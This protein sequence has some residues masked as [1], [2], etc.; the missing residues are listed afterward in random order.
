MA[1]SRSWQGWILAPVGLL[2][3][4]IAA[5]LVY[6]RVAGPALHPDPGA[7]PSV[8]HR[9][10]SPRWSAAVERSRGIIRNSMAGQNLPGLSVAVGAGGETV[11]SEGFGWADIESRAPVT[12]DTRFRIGTAST[13]L[14]SAAVG[15]LLE[16]GAL[17]LEGE[18]QTYLPEFP[19]KPWAVTLRQVMSNT[20]G[21]GDDSGPAGALYRQRCEQ[22]AEALQHFAKDALLFKP[23]TQHRSSTYGW[24]VVSAAIEGAAGRPFLAYMNDQIFRPLGMNNTGA[25]S[26][27]DEN[28]EGVGEEGEDPP[29]FTLLHH[30][31]LRPLGIGGGEARPPSKPATM[32]TRGFGPKPYF[33]YGFHVLY[34]RNLSC[35]AGSMAFLSTPSDLVRFGLA[36]D[37]GK[38]LQPAT[39]RSLQTSQRLASGEETGYGLGWEI[40]TVRL[41]GEP[42]QAAGHDGEL[43]GRRV[44]SLI[45]FREAGI[46]VAV[47]SNMAD[48]ETPVLARQVAE[49]FAQP[50]PKA[51]G[52]L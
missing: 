26:A 1:N 5:T 21:V 16:K 3:F 51:T 2:A 23:G 13:V 32:Y 8:T 48:A 29:I 36:M 7:I 43:M 35:Y 38:L 40:D 44:A 27:A 47:L 17:N 12:P 22:P 41:G 19:K 18:I 50:A 52:R 46:V 30:M 14:T 39:V 24:I 49:A 45:T 15:V 31:I 34:P 42:R 6:V 10:P 20:A 25:E 4:A 9:Q 33:R 28:P 11:W 37:A